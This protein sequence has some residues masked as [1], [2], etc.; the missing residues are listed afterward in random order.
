MTANAAT[1]STEPVDTNLA[2]TRLPSCLAAAGPQPLGREVCDKAR[3]SQKYWI[4]VAPKCTVTTIGDV[5]RHGDEEL[6]LAE[7]GGRGNL[8]QLERIGV[9]IHL[10]ESE[11]KVNNGLAKHVVTR[12]VTYAGKIHAPGDVVEPEDFVKADEPEFQY[13]DRNGAHRVSPSR[14]HPSGE[15]KLRELVKRGFIEERKRVAAVQKAI[16]EARGE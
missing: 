1:R 10:S 2:M 12:S 5:V 8:D 16:K 15:E 14:T 4:A 6:T 7:I 11:F 9:V 3:K 13:T